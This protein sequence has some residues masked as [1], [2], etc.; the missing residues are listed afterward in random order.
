MIIK[1]ADGNV[2]YDGSGKD[3]ANYISQPYKLTYDTAS[4]YEKLIYFSN[5]IVSNENLLL[6]SSIEYVQPD[7]AFALKNG[8]AATMYS[9]LLKKV[10]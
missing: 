5:G 9:M 1:G 7:A 10:N 2:S 6:L 8:Y 4:H 3:L